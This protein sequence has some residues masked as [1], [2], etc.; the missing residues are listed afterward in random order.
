M[1]YTYKY[2][3]EKGENIAKNKG[4]FELLKKTDVMQ[5]SL[6]VLNFYKTDVN[7]KS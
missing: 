2:Y 5:W 6:I 1:T 7:K 4:Y 3:S